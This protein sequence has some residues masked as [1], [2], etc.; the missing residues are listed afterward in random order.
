MQVLSRYLY[1]LHKILAQIFICFAFTFDFGLSW[2]EMIRPWNH[3]KYRVTN[4]K[5]HIDISSIYV[6]HKLTTLIFGMSVVEYLFERAFDKFLKCVQHGDHSS[7][8]I[9]YAVWAPQPIIQLLTLRL[10]KI[11]TWLAVFIMIQNYY[12]LQL[13]A[14][15]LFIKVVLLCSR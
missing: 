4:I 14:K 3:L 15:H 1:L 8:H 9:I 12:L 5:S 11:Q 6:F 2:I 13:T 7:P 10:P